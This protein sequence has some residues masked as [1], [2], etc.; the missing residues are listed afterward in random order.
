[1]ARQRSFRGCIAEGWKLFARNARAHL[2]FGA[3]YALVCGLGCAAALMAGTRLYTAHALPIGLA[4]E[5]GLPADE[6]CA[7]WP[8]T[9]P[10]YAL[11]AAALLALTVGIYV[12][13]GAGWAVAQAYA[14]GGVPA[15]GNPFGAWKRVGAS[16]WRCLL[17]DACA[18]L[19]CL[20][21]GAAVVLAVR[22]WG[23]LAAAWTLPPLIL[24]YIYVWTI[25]AMGRQ[26]C[27]TVG[28]GVGE[29]W[30]SALRNG[31]R[32]FG[33]YL[34]ILVL[35]G[36]PLAIT[37]FVFL[38]PVALF[39][40]SSAA[41]AASRLAGEAPGLPPAY[42]YL[43]AVVATVAVAGCT[44]AASLRRLPLVLLATGRP[45]GGGGAAAK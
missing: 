38:T 35:T 19:P 16:A 23:M 3:P 20:L 22:T 36:I 5:M 28:A 18:A 34:L 39:P 1:M 33:S 11:A 13:K 24:I 30:L 7:L 26:L 29:A 6:A 9:M 25:A 40:L 17:F 14:D 31:W 37:A 32:T 8:L 41:D 43:F 27:L 45:R 4:V 10:D 12:G 15:L 42:P 21:L 2:K 44:L